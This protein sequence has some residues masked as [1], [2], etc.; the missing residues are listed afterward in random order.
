MEQ[1]LAPFFTLFVDVKAQT[2]G[3]KERKDNNI[4]FLDDSDHLLPKIVKKAKVERD[5]DEAGK[6]IGENKFPKVTLS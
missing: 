5:G 3:E 4:T 6:E 2:S 1:C